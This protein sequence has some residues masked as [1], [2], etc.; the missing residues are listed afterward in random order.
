MLHCSVTR[1]GRGG[2]W[3][4]VIPSQRQALA[5]G[6]LPRPTRGSC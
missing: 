5:L 4:L 2:N 3:F 1:A 6:N